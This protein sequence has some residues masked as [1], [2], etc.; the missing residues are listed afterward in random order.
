MPP[1]RRSSKQPSIDKSSSTQS[2]KLNDAQSQ[3]VMMVEDCVLEDDGS[4]ESRPFMCKLR[5]PK[6]DS[7]CLFLF[8]NGGR[9]V[10]EAIQYKEEF[11]SW[12]IGDTIQH[13][14]GMLMLTTVDPLFLVM[15]YLVKE[16]QSGKFMTLDQIVID[17]D[18]PECNRLHECSG[19]SELHQITEVKGDDDFRAYRFDKDKTLSWLKLKTEIVADVL[20]QKDVSVSSSGAHSSMFIRSKK[21]EAVDKEQYIKYA[22]G[23]VS[24]YLPPQI[25]DDLRDYLGVADIP[26]PVK[27][28][29]EEP[30]AKRVKLEDIA[31]SEDYSKTN[32]LQK[33]NSK[34]TKLTVAQKKL[35]KVDKT[36]MKS[37]SSF[38]SPKVK[39]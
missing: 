3:W 11:R 8:A 2:K 15:P 38:F 29:S 31:P 32:G 1:S 36:G 10:Y 24:D 26:E 14:G 19:L 18:Y 4:E 37:I 39:T 22:C 6:S 20:Q 28:P 33:Q 16:G 25:A 12:F 5:H 23:M 9:D 17:E 35:S 30:P 34:E 13:D 27:S 21:E 7:G